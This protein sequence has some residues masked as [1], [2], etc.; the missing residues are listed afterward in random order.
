MELMLATTNSGKIRELTGLLA[1]AGITAAGLPE[2]MVIEPPR[3]DGTTF[4]ENVAIKAAYYAKR[5]G[6]PVLADDSGLEVAAL[7][8]EPGVLS[9]RYGGGETTFDE[10][11]RLILDRLAETESSDRKA[12][13]VC[14]AALADPNGSVVHL[15]VGT[16]DGSI[17]DAPFGTGGFGYDPIFVP[18]GF[19]R[20]FGELPSEIKDSLSHRSKA[21]AEMLPFLREFLAV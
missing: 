8:G 16:C 9:A 21:I 3:E 19:D 17:A 1:E 5:L 20:T 18:D 7:K 14:A 10:K 11:M 2:D 6:M 15:T 13:F 4:A 12:R